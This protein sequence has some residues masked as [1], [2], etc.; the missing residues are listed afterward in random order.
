M[1]DDK[2]LLEMREIAA[3]GGAGRAGPPLDRRAGGG[4]ASGFRQGPA[5]IKKYV[6]YGA[7]PRAAQAMV[8][9][10]KVRAAA[11]GRTDVAKE[12]LAAVIVPR[13][14]IASC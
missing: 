13:C 5:A 11:N 12:D 14:G 1:V 9:A 8:L 3:K 4:H 2:R 6:R 10:A 7:S